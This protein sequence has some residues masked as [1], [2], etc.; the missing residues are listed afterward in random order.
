MAMP[1]A[2]T[3]NKRKTEKNNGNAQRE[4]ISQYFT[5]A[6]IKTGEKQRKFNKISQRRFSAQNTQKLGH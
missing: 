3:F 2:E 5:E 1:M 6:H 4:Y